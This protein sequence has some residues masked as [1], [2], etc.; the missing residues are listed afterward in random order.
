M[1]VVCVDH[2]TANAI[3]QELAVLLDSKLTTG[4]AMSVPGV[5]IP[6]DAD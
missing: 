5:E 1:S 4:E 3:G 2:A 6:P